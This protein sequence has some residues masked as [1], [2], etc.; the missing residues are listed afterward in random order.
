MG[1][2]TLYIKE[3]IQ[4]ASYDCKMSLKKEVVACKREK[5]YATY[6]GSSSVF[7]LGGDRNNGR[8]VRQLRKEPDVQL[9]AQK[10]L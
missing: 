10:I 7:N 5:L 1:N 9:K 3:G 4:G 6:T 2:T 8:E